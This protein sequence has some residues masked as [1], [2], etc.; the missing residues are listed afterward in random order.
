MAIHVQPR[1]SRNQLV[2]QLPDRIAIRLTAPP[3]DGAANALCCAFLAE[4]LDVPKSRV[5]VVRGDTSRQ[6]LIR[7][8]GADAPHILARL[9]SL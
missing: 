6:K 4:C 9:Q 7:V 3:V 8:R 5:S 1:A 2:A